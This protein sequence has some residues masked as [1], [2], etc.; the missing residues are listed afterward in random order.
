MRFEEVE[1]VEVEGSSS[2]LTSLSSAVEPCETWNG[3]IKMVGICSDEKHAVMDR[4]WIISHSCHFMWKEWQLHWSSYII[5]YSSYT[6][7]V[8]NTSP[9]SSYLVWRVWP[10]LAWKDG[11]THCRWCRVKVVWTLGWAA[12]A[13]GVMERQSSAC[14]DGAQDNGPGHDFLHISLRFSPHVQ[15]VFFVAVPFDAEI[16]FLIG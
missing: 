12:Q 8:C 2:I 16:C 14:I 4:R 11:S 10:L 15:K 1:A 3:S 9:P 7:S 13:G 6:V 5:A